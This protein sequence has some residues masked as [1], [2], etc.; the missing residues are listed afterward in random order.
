[1]EECETIF[2]QLRK[3]LTH[4]PVLKIS[5]LDKEFIVCTDDFKGGLGGVLMQD[6]QLRCYES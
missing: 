6:G 3:L 4:A 2:E 1:M 5:Y